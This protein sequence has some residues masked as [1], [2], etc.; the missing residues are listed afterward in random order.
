MSGRAVDGPVDKGVGIQEISALK[1]EIC[2]V[3]LCA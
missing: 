3:D 1:R 2:N